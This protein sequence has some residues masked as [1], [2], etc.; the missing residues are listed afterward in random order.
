MMSLILSFRQDRLQRGY[1][2]L[3]Q[4]LPWMHIKL[5]ELDIDDCED[6]RKKVRTLNESFLIMYLL[7]TPQLKKGA[8]AARGDDTSTLK[9]LIAAWINQDFR[10]SS[11]LRADDK[12]SRGFAHDICGRLLCPAEWDWDNDL[13][14]MTSSTIALY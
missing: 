1:I 3:A 12:Q 2:S 8:D 13:F 11:L 4:V 9:D 5:A 14:A 6:M 10:P 7:V